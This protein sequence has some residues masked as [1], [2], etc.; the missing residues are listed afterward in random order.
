MFSI[1]IT[2]LELFS[3]TE[4]NYFGLLRF[5]RQKQGIMQAVILARGRWEFRVTLSYITSPK[6]A[7]ATWNPASNKKINFFL[8]RINGLGIVFI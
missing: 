5:V 3:W 7:W 6:S 4:L 1:S 2:I 8:V